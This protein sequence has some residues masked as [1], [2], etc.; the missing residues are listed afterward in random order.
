MSLQ[1]RI[2][3]SK[4]GYQFKNKTLLERAL[5]HS[6]KSE[7]NYERLEFLGDS[8]LDFVV[9]DYLFK[10]SS[11]DEGNLTITRSHFVSENYLCKIFD[12]LKLE[13]DVILGKSFKGNISRAIKGDVVESIIAAI[14]LDSNLDTVYHFIENALHL[15]SF[16][17]IKNDNY[18]SQLQE[19]VQA[20]FKCKMQYE[21][22]P[23]EDG[24]ISTFYMD[25]DA[26]ES[27]KGASKIEAEQ[28]AARKSIKKLFLIEN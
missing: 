16:R 14:Y 10:H 28:E 17:S 20:S 26:I 18:K 24:F 22:E 15:D 6:S 2:K 8:I 7:Q 1:V 9:G 3:V 21:T 12:E 27:G 5:T 13:K 11:E 4:L 25:E 23:V 19:L